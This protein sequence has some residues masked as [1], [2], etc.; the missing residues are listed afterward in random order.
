M[1]T[2]PTVGSRYI[3]LRW[4]LLSILLS[5]S[6]QLSGA[7][8]HPSS[9]EL[10]ATISSVGALQDHVELSLRFLLLQL[11]SNLPNCS[12]SSDVHLLGD[13]GLHIAIDVSLLQDLVNLLLI[14][15][16]LKTRLLLLLLGQPL[17]EARVI[18]NCGHALFANHWCTFT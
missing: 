18:G 14:N 11:L 8:G 3:R 1:L 10:K 6:S 2:T 15:S 16:W 9:L 7:A 17:L 12:T 4:L 13:L 5:F